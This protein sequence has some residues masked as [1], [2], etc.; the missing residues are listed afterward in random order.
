MLLILVKI[1]FVNIII[2]TVFSATKEES[3]I[4]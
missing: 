3:M 2:T 1:K 4:Y